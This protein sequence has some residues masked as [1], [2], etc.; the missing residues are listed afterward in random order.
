MGQEA[1]VRANEIASTLRESG[2]A[3]DL[4][5]GV[6]G[7]YAEL[8]ALEISGRDAAKYLHGQTTN[9]VNSLE[10]GRWH[11]NARVTRRGEVEALFTLHRLEDERFV[12][13]G[14]AP[15]IRELHANLDKFLFAD[16]VD[17]ALLEGSWLALV[18]ERAANA[19]SGER[20]A[21]LE[22]GGLWLERPFVGEV[23]IL[24]LIVE[25]AAMGA[26]RGQL[27]EAGLLLE[28]EVAEAVE[29]LRLESGDP[30]VAVDVAE[31]GRL[32]PEL[33]LENRCV[34]YA[35]GCYVGQ[36]VI[37]R[38][39][40]YGSLPRTLRA[41]VL[42]RDIDVAVGE[43]VLVEG[44]EKV[45]LY[46]SGGHSVT[47]DAPIRWALLGRNSRTPGAKLKLLV[48]GEVVNAEV[49]LQP[50][51]RAVETE[52]LVETL[53][54]EAVRRFS[55]GDSEG[56]LGQMER[57][58]A[59]DPSHRDAYEL[60]GVM[61]AKEGRW[62]EA[63][64]FFRRLE[65]IAPD[66]PMVH[67]NLSIAYMKLGDKTAA[68]EQAAAATAKRFAA[69]SRGEKSL[70]EFAEGQRE[71]ER[72]LTLRKLSM[73]ERVLELDADDPVALFGAATAKLQLELWG[74]AVDLFRR[75]VN[76]DKNNSA[77][78][79]GLGKALEATGDPI[80]ATE[81]YRQGVEVA[82]KRGD[83]MPLREME[84]RVAIL[85]VSAI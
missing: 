56:A 38:A 4:S 62:H 50:L 48:G 3:L 12:V 10:V 52:E 83:L 53:F 41:L 84:H 47:L 65:E 8:L 58:L 63:V 34:S 23:V 61:M 79:L 14:V 40:T 17:L 81:T 66:E 33:A 19:V 68:E 76:G 78:W 27:Q 13:V 72:K 46:S 67:S 57:L 7:S 74:D 43:D 64:D 73:F 29:A 54:G 77:A 55:G 44:G 69:M 42:E 35:K 82:S 30:F 28:G 60:V 15:E 59:L 9:D 1:C 37:A 32:L 21:I 11:E 26:L 22:A 51:Y 24:C 20:G 31:K 75:A 5:M 2:G 45:G 39:R 16:R 71:M 80:G 18:G 25:G 36:E 85:G 6:E 70:A 49:R